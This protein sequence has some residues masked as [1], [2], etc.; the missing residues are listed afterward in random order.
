MVTVRVRSRAGRHIWAI[1]LA[2]ALLIGSTGAWIVTARNAGSHVA[3]TNTYSVGVPRIDACDIG[4]SVLR[5]GHVDLSFGD[6]IDHAD[7]TI[8][9]TAG[10]PVVLWLPGGPNSFATAAYAANQ[11]AVRRAFPSGQIVALDPPRDASDRW[12]TERCSGSA[13]QASFYHSLV[14]DSEALERAA[15]AWA[16]GC[17]GDPSA[18]YGPTQEAQVLRAVARFLA[19]DEAVSIYAASADAMI[20]STIGA[21]GVRVDS[22]VLDSP[23]P[24]TADGPTFVA[25]QVESIRAAAPALLGNDWQTL[26]HDVGASPDDSAF[27]EALLR[28]PMGDVE[29]RRSLWLNRSAEDVREAGDQ[30]FRRYAADRYSGLN[31]LELAGVCT[32][33][34]WPA[35]DDYRTTEQGAI[36]KYGSAGAL[37]RFL[38][39]YYL[40]CVYWQ[41]TG[42][43]AAASS[44]RFSADSVVLLFSAGDP[45]VGAE[46]G[47]DWTAAIGAGASGAFRAIKVNV[48]RHGVL[49]LMDCSAAELVTPGGVSSKCQNSIGQLGGGSGR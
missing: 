9:G 4:N 38:Y 13:A 40:P 1:P 20:V 12:A 43:A 17:V 19:P 48:A 2:I 36:V 44:P 37:A 47:Q 11:A 15:R 6:A 8:D 30:F 49:G 22:V 14:G 18:G 41:R 7:F 23:V 46:G 25:N 29:Q 16:E 33:Y 26:L 27:A 24:L 5:C 35:I 34:T 3:Q 10:E 42:S 28:M 21:I 45:V 32:S 39:S 31:A